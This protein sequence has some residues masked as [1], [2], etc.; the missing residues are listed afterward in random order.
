MD[1]DPTEEELSE[2]IDSLSNS[3]TPGED[4][5]PADVLL[6]QLHAL[7]LQCWRQRE[8]PHI[9]RDAK[10]V[11]LCKNKGDKGDCSNYREICLLSVAGKIFT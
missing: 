5:I 8:T 1:E 10:I 7:L 4:G 9:M 3:K 2:A 6:P 11:T